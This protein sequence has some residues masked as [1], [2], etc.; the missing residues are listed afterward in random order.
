[1]YKGARKQNERGGAGKGGKGEGV[2][3]VG[4]TMFNI[5]ICINTA[6]KVNSLRPYRPQKC[7][8]QI[9][10]QILQHTFY[11]IGTIYLDPSI[12]TYILGQV[13]L[14]KSVWICLFGPVYLTQFIWTCLLE[15]VY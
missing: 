13:H 5:Q 15:P 4:K 1:M 7:C 10:E 14:D 11:L 12:G 3:M 8:P 6:T 9:L 2:K